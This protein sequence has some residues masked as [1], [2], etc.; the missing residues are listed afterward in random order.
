[1]VQYF[2]RYTNLHTWIRFH[3]RVHPF[4]YVIVYVVVIRVIRRL[5]HGFKCHVQQNV[6]RGRIHVDTTMFA[7][8]VRLWYMVTNG[9]VAYHINTRIGTD[10]TRR[11]RTYAVH[12]RHRTPLYVTVSPRY[13]VTNFH[14][15][16][17][18]CTLPPF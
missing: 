12:S 10:N 14:V 13:T 17:L 3:H 11:G 9:H 16:A 8:V 6:T 4:G 2:Q 15:V 7:Y 1:M 5:T 18:H